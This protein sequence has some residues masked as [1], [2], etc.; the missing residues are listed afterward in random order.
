MAGSEFAM[1]FGSWGL[2][3]LNFYCVDL[4]PFLFP[5]RS[6]PSLATSNKALAAQGKLQFTE[7]NSNPEKPHFYDAG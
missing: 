4:V 6:P 3:D 1:L 7:M 5:F 2:E